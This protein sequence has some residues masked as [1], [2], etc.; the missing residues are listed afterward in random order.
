[1]TPIA[2]PRRLRGF[3]LLEL[4]VAI[5]ILAFVSIIAWRG[6][7]SLVNTRARLEPEGDAVRALLTVFGQVERDLA[8]TANPAFF[9][10]S[11][12][13]VRVRPSADGPVLELVRIA[14]HADNEATS[15]QVVF[16]RVTDGALWRQ[17]SP[18]ARAFAAVD[19]DKLSNVKLLADVKALR[20]RVWRDQQG[21]IEYGADAGGAP[22]AVAAMPPGLEFTIERNDGKVYRRVVL[23]G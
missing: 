11:V 21:W 22:G 10:L 1:M 19:S 18:P 2:L 4:L 14:P 23:V 8:H 16:Y 15:V 5:A 3:T 6:L 13:A 9:A 20:V 17:S 12:P 7:D